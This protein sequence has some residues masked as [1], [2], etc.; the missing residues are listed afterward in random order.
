ME[1]KNLIPSKKILVEHA[2]ICYLY[3]KK[4]AFWIKDTILF[5]RNLI[6]YIEKRRMYVL[7]IRNAMLNWRSIWI[8]SVF[9]EDMASDQKK[10]IL[11]LRTCFLD[12]TRD[13]HYV[14]KLAIWYL[15]ARKKLLIVKIK[16]L[17]DDPILS[18]SNTFSNCKNSIF[19]C[20]VS[21]IS[22]H[23]VKKPSQASSCNWQFR[24][25]RW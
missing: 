13:F 18:L 19:S 24:Y 7:R 15:H 9:S 12:W 3:I 17:I 5:I 16:F 1:S 22:T 11:F 8:S 23:E 2:R 6:T 10:S 21:R 4:C 20:V 14:L 25:V